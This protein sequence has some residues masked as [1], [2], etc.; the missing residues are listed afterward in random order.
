MFNAFCKIS[1]TGL[2]KSPMFDFESEQF[3]SA[4]E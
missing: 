4:T 3:A 1:M 2:P